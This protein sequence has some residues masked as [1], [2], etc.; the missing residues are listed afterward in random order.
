ME[1]GLIVDN[2]MVLKNGHMICKGNVM[3]GVG[4]ECEVNNG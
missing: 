3:G 4:A 2:D 1:N